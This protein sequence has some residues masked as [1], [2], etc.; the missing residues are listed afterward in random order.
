MI[1]IDPTQKQY[2]NLKYAICE[3]SEQKFLPI[4]LSL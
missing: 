1:Q 4:E 3:R 2:N